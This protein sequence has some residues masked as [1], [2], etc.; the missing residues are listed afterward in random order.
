MFLV[1]SLALNVLSALNVK[2]SFPSVIPNLL[3]C[4]FSLLSAAL[5]ATF[6]PAACNRL[7]DSN[8]MA[9]PEKVHVPTI[10]AVFFPVMVL[11]MFSTLSLLN[12]SF[13]DCARLLPLISSMAMNNCKKT[14]FFIWFVD[15]SV[16]FSALY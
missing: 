1:P 16:I 6:P 2:A 13:K 5:A 14:D 11:T 12:R 4:S 15:F 9:D 7:S 10:L 8:S 3:S